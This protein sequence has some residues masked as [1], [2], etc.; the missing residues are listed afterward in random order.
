M[1]FGGIVDQTCVS[2]QRSCG[3]SGNCVIYENEG[4]SRG[5]FYALGVTLSIN[6]LF[7]YASLIAHR[8]RIHQRAMAKKSRGMFKD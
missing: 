8:R 2:W 4:M 3:S 5:L 6:M 1:V 7:Y